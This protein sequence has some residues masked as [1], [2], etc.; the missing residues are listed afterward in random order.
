MLLYVSLLCTHARFQL[1]IIPRLT[2]PASGGATA[3]LD[4]GRVAAVGA[5][6]AVQTLL[7]AAVLGP[8]L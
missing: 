7:A 6:G 5:A 8:E 3:H 2:V 1:L 4:L